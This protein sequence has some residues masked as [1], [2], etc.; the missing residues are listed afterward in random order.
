MHLSTKQFVTVVP[1]I[2]PLGFAA[3]GVVFVGVVGVVGEALVS[4]GDE[5]GGSS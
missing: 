2:P 1:F 5:A 3:P 4:A